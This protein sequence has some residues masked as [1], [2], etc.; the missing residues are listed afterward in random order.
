MILPSN[1]EYRHKEAY[2]R[3]QLAKLHGVPSDSPLIAPYDPNRRPDL[4]KK[5]VDYVPPLPSSPV[6]AAPLVI[7]SITG[8]A[9]PIND[10]DVPFV[11]KHRPVDYIKRGMFDHIPRA[12]S[13][14]GGYILVGEQ[15]VVVKCA[16]A[17]TSIPATAGAGAHKR[18]KVKTFSRKSSDNL[19]L[20]IR[21]LPTGSLKCML[22]LTYPDDYPVDGKQVKKHFDLMR[23]WLR[24]RG[25]DLLWFLEFQVR[26]A[27]HFHAYLTGYP[28]GGVSAVA[29]HWYKVVGSGDP[30]HLD[31]HL[32]KL[33]GRPCLEML[34]NPHAASYYATKYASKT[35]QKQVPAEYQN[36]GRFWGRSANLKP[37]WTYIAFRGSESVEQ[38]RCLIANLRLAWST[39]MEVYNWLRRPFPNGIQWGASSKF[40]DEYDSLNIV[41]F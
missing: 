28:A 13:V 17:N 30:K 16:I 31:W 35:C 32:G 15:D 34:R 9:P 19:K 39:S 20:N 3:A 33:S 37:N 14:F 10:L 27:P 26:G 25:C 23:R 11:P 8:K 2:K 24:A 38:V 5:I 6:P 36:V 4:D 40:Y 29:H 41:P 7:K 18:G 1:G 12:E 22:T 21:N